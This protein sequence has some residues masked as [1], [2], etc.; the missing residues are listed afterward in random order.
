I[1]SNERDDKT[2]RVLTYNIHSCVGLD[3]KLAPGRVARIIR[4]YDPD[5]VALQEVDVK[6]RRSRGEDQT[7]RLADELQMHSAFCCT[8]NRSWEKYG[9]VLLSKFPLEVIA[10][11]LFATNNPGVEPRGVFLG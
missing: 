6:R 9:H 2:V 3:G 1:A 7:A 4:G 11:D 8:V 10:S 5:I